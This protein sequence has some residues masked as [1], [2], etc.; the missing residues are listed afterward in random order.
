MAGLSAVFLYFRAVAIAL[1]GASYSAFWFVEPGPDLRIT[2]KPLS[3]SVSCCF[4]NAGTRGSLPGVAAVSGATALGLPPR[5]WR[6]GV[7]VLPQRSLWR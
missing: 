5:G 2:A 4:V 6:R 7:A 3:F 1:P